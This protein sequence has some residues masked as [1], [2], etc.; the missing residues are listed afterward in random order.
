VRRRRRGVWLFLSVVE[1]VSCA[2]RSDL[3]ALLDRGDVARTYVARACRMWL[4]R[5]SPARAVA[6]VATR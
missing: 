2:S 3:C 4:G 6:A 5:T 1:R